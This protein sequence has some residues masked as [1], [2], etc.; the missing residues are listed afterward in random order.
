MG[1]K[2]GVL[3]LHTATLPPLGADTWVQAQIIRALDRSSYDVHVACVPGRSGSR[4]PTYQA[5]R[6]IPDIAIVPVNLGR[7]RSGHRS[8]RALARAV[9]GTVAAL[10]G[11]I[12]LVLYV[13]RR[14]IAIIHT[15]DRPRDAVTCVLLARISGAR[16][17]VQAH[18]VYGEWMSPLLRWAL[19]HADALIAVSRF[20]GSSLAAAGVE[21]RRIHVALNAIDAALWCPGEDRDDARRMLG[22]PP[23]APVVMMVCRLFATKGPD[24]LIRAL[25]SVRA[26]LPAVRLVIVGADLMQDGVY[27]REL[28]ALVATLDLQGSVVFTGRREDVARLLAA[29]DVFAMPSR[30]EPFGLVFLEAMAMKLPVVALDSGGTPEVVRHGETGLLSEPGDADGLADNLATLLGDPDLR[31]HMGERGRCDVEQSFTLA[32]MAGD[33]ARA[34]TAILGGRRED[35]RSPRSGTCGPYRRT[36]S[37]RWWSASTTMVMR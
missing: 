1:R 21:R 5:I 14:R 3:F 2:T 15:S 12:R 20:V 4:T 34:Y 24:A 25:A 22:V 30:E 28:E 18:V 9:V 11:M 7:E 37:R 6:N 31:R 26:K 29:A 27:T 35:L 19:H 13:R 16:S 10:A 23:E 17:I 36:A 32:R 33:V 8:V